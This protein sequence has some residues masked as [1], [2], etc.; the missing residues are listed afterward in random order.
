MNVLR[1]LNIFFLGGKTLHT[2]YKPTKRENIQ[3]SSI[4][5]FIM[6]N[7]VFYGISIF[8]GNLIPNLSL[9]KNNSGD[10]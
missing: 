2:H 3:S 1:F 7:F 9:W 4:L 5:I 6:L 10:I 8:V